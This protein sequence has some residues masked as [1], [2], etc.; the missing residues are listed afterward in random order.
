MAAALVVA[1]S[2]SVVPDDMVDDEVPTE[3]GVGH[4]DERT[5]EHEVIVYATIYKF[6][7]AYVMAIFR[8]KLYF[9]LFVMFL[10]VISICCCCVC[11]ADPFDCDLKG[12]FRTI[13]R[14][15]VKRDRAKGSR[16]SESS[17]LLPPVTSSSPA[18]LNKGM[19]R[20]EV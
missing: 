1:A 3:V 4:K 2:E 20:F 15:G 11:I 10:C 16:P 9:W 6:L 14:R 13:I 7:Y 5:G 19:I 12:K 8:R 18:D 17:P